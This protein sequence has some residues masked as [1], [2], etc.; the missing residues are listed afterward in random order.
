MRNRN[1]LL[2]ACP[3]ETVPP[4]Q[5]GMRLQ[6]AQLFGASFYQFETTVLRCQ[7]NYLVVE[8]QP[9]QLVDRRSAPRYACTLSI[10]YTLQS[11]PP[12]T[13]SEPPA[14]PKEGL[15]RDISLGGMSLLI[16]ERAPVGTHLIV[17]A[18][19]GGEEP[20]V[21]LAEALRCKPV[22]A[23]SEGSPDLPTYQIACRFL[24]GTP[25]HEPRLRRYLM[26]RSAS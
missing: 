18:M 7:K 19:L 4:L 17:E 22:E 3:A 25:D 15:I 11:S 16:G 24:H 2:I 10:S 1:S 8:M 12:H 26:N 9:P 20:T 14:T 23:T 13:R 21:L 6:L 5:P